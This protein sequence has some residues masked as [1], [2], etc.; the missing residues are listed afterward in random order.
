MAKRFM[1]T[2]RRPDRSERAERLFLFLRFELLDECG[3]MGGWT[4]L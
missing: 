1:S 4:P 2:R 3:E